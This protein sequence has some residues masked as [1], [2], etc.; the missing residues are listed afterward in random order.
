MTTRRLGFTSGIMHVEARMDRSSVEYGPVDGGVVDLR[1]TDRMATTNAPP[2]P[3]V[4]EIN[5]RPLG[6]TASRIIETVYGID[7]SGVAIALAIDD[8]ERAKSL[9]RP[10]AKGAQHTGAMVLIPAEFDQTCEGIFDSDDIWEELLARRP[11]L[12][13]NSELCYLS[14]TLA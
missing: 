8:K 13:K 4:L 9:S 10:F 6:L 5:P 14:N 2:V 7:Y 3:W 11:D 1:P 12:G